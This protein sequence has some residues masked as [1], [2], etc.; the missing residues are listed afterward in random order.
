VRRV[1]Y[2]PLTNVYLSDHRAERLLDRKGA[3]TMTTLTYTDRPQ[4]N[5]REHGVW[6]TPDE[7]EWLDWETP[8]GPTDAS[9]RARLERAAFIYQGAGDPHWRGQPCYLGD[10]ARMA[11]GER[12]V[13]MAC[14]CRA[15]VSAGALGS[16]Q[17]TS[18]V[19]RVLDALNLE[20]LHPIEAGQHRRQA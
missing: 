12:V 19:D 14:G 20:A 15:S 4:S 9:A 16:L 1:G 11:P 7:A 10:Q 13:I 5:V 6:F 2:S 18:P 3:T 8:A 17:W